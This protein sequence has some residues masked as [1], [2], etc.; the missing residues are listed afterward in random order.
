MGFV[1]EFHKQNQNHT[2]GAAAVAAFPGSHIASIVV[3][4]KKWDGV[5]CHCVLFAT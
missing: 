4:F 1:E 5:V 2:H 3:V